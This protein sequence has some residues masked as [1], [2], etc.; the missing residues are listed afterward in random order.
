M[1]PLK[2]EP[3]QTKPSYPFRANGGRRRHVSDELQNVTIENFTLQDAIGD[4]LK[5][6][7]L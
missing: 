4:N 6:K 3:E 7:R 2:A 5:L 1:S